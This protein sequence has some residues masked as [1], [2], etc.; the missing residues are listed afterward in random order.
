MTSPLEQNIAG[1]V[2]GYATSCVGK[3]IAE[4]YAGLIQ[5]KQYSDD[6]MAL[7]SLYEGPML[8]DA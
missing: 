7:Y 2:S 3:F 1:E 8:I 6:F 5:G 4:V